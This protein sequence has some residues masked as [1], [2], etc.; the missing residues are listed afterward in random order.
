M[1]QL[2]SFDGTIGGLCF[3]YMAFGA[4]VAFS[5]HSLIGTPVIGSLCGERV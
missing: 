1:E 5:T 2:Q 4:F 3:L